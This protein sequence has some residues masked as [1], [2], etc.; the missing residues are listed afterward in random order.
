MERKLESVWSHHH[1]SQKRTLHYIH[2]DLW[3]PSKVTSHGGARY[4]LFIIDF[5]KSIIYFLKS[6]SD[7]FQKFK[8]WKTQVENQVGRQVKTLRTDNELEH[9]SNEFNIFCQK[10][11]IAKHKI[12][13]ET[14]QQ[15]SLAKRMSKTILE[16]I[17]YVLSTSRFSNTF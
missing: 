2:L 8:E 4:F 13:R 6:K 12:V 1:K 10:E 15:N 16:R 9:L 17:R 14:P 5:L 11:R 3:G 7:T